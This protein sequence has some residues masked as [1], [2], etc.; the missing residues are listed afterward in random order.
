MKIAIFSGSVYGTADEVAR[1]AAA[2]LNQAGFEV[3]QKPR[4]SLDELLAF[5]PDALLC[6]TSSTGMGELPESLLPLYSEMRDRFPAWSGKP[7]AVLALGDSSYP[8]F[9]GAG[10]LVRELFAE[11][12]LREVLPMLRV[13]GSETVTP[14][15][16]AQPW[17]EELI[18]ALKA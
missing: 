15:V 4:V 1:D 13:D 10:E 17:L 8:E 6:V 18:S 16:D 12:G 7:A 5:A 14:E 11:L 3:L 9:C 2:R